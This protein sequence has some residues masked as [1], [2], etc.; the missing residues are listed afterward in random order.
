[1]L[2]Q[3]LHLPYL[4]TI[5]PV[6]AFM[7]IAGGVFWLTRSSPESDGGNE[8]QAEVITK[9]AVLP[10]TKAKPKDQ[11]HAA[12]RQGNTVDVLVA[13]PETRACYALVKSGRANWLS[14]ITTEASQC[15]PA[16]VFANRS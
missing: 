11:R 16:R 8:L 4:Y 7:A 3:L 5:L 6:V 15:Q 14:M 1:M 9:P 10:A 13:T 2:D 12:R